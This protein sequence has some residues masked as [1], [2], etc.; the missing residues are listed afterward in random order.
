MKILKYLAGF[1]TAIL[2]Y[3]I[4][5][6][7]YGP[8][9]FFVYKHLLHERDMQWKNVNELANINEDLLR[10][11]NN[12]L[13]DYDTL[14]VHAKVMG[15][16]QEDEHFVRIVGLSGE[17]N[18]YSMTGKVYSVEEPE[19]ISDKIMKITAICAGLLVFAFFFALEFA[20][21]KAKT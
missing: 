1:W 20:A 21:D 19:F 5:S 6:F 7:S 12:V 9:G 4:F 2:I 11:K 18:A 10:V 15:Y 14:M 3:S 8:R 13:F 17:E 16:G